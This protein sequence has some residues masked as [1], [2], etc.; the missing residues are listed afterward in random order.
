MPEVAAGRRFPPARAAAS[1]PCPDPAAPTWARRGRDRGASPRA[2]APGAAGRARPPWPAAAGA[3]RDRGAERSGAVERRERPGSARL[4]STRRGSARLGTARPA[5]SRFGS[6]RL[7]SALPDSAQHGTARVG[8]AQ[9]GSARL[10]SARLGAALARPRRRARRGSAAAG[11]RRAAGGTVSPRAS[12]AVGDGAERVGVEQE[13]EAPSILWVTSPSSPQLCSCL[14][15]AGNAPRSTPGFT[16]Q[17]QGS[18]LDCWL[19]EGK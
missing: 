19:L 14:A 4:G 1:R 2:A 17:V 8:A 9:L 16:W 10:G 7:S 6:V 13:L 18:V 15:R 11:T 12:Q 5:L 3:V